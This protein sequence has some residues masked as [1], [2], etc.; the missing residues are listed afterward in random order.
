MIGP[1]RWKHDRCQWFRP[2]PLWLRNSHH[3]RNNNLVPPSQ[4]TP[5]T[6]DL[7]QLELDRLHDNVDNFQRLRSLTHLSFKIYRN[8]SFRRLFLCDH[9]STSPVSTP[10]MHDRPNTSQLSLPIPFISIC[11]WWVS[12]TMRSKCRGWQTVPAWIIQIT[13]NND[14]ASKLCSCEL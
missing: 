3:R 5:I 14:L 8:A 2:S 10:I 6:G 9:L 13:N 4:L 12:F 1:G 7:R 11:A